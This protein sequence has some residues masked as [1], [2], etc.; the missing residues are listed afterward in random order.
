MSKA[1]E[2]LQKNL[3]TGYTLMKTICCLCLKTKGQD[4]WEMQDHGQ[5]KEFSHGYCPECYRKIMQKIRLKA[6]YSPY[7]MNLRN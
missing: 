7:Y 2:K 6:S 4:G 5:Y 3:G 1:Q